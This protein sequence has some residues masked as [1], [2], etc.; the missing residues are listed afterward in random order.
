MRNWINI[1]E[2]NELFPGYEQEHRAERLDKWLGATYGWDGTKPRIFYHATTKH[3]DSFNTKGI[4]TTSVL[5]MNYDV[6]RHGAFFAEDPDFALEYI[7]KN[8]DTAKHYNVKDD[9]V[10][11]PVYLSVQNPFDLRDNAL[12]QMLGD[13]NAVEAFANHNIDIRSIYYHMGEF[14]RWEC[15]DGEDG[16]NFV[17]TLV[18]MG[19]DGAIMTEKAQWAENGTVW[20]V[21]SPSQIKSATGNRGSFDTNSDKIR[22]SN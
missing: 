15:F 17:S 12:S 13:E 19:F 10:I 14:E 21:F 20:V 3:F 6:E 9:A 18:H 16:E 8:L 7:S 11:I 22:E 1:I 2:Q 5:G 4:G